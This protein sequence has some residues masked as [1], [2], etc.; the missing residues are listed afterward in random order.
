MLN[1]IDGRRGSGGVFGGALEHDLPAEAQRIPDGQAVCADELAAA[2]ALV[3]S[4][5]DSAAPMSAPMSAIRDRLEDAKARLAR[6][7]QAGAPADAPEVQQA[8]RELDAIDAERLAHGGVFAGDAQK[9]VIPAGQ[10]TLS[11]LLNHCYGAGPLTRD[12]CDVRG[13]EIPSCIVDA[14]SQAR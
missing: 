7:L 2:Y 5:T 13:A 9:G 4:L 6:A 10:A 14:A 3:E 8:Q 1:A 12:A 11:A